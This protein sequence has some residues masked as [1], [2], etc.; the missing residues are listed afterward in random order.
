M[1]E[2]H[3]KAAQVNHLHA[4]LLNMEVLMLCDGTRRKKRETKHS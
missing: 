1:S 3:M 2:D 4:I